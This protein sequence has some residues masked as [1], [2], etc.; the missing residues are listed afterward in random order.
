M[1][2]TLPLIDDPCLPEPPGQAKGFGRLLIDSPEDGEELEALP[3]RGLS[4]SSRIEGLNARTLVVTRFRNFHETPLRAVYTFPLPSEA[5]VTSFRLKADGRIIQ[6]KVLERGEALE[7]H[8]EAIAKGHTSALLEEEAGETFTLEL[9]NIPPTCEVETELELVEELPVEDRK[10]VWRFPLVCGEKYIPGRPLPG[11]PSGTGHAPDTDLVPEGSRISPPR[12]LPGMPNPIEASFRLTLADGTLPEGVEPQASLELEECEVC[13]TSPEGRS[14]VL[15]DRVTAPERDLILRWELPRDALQGDLRVVEQ[16]EDKGHF[17]ASI[18]V[19]ESD[20]APPPRD[21]VLLVDRSGSMGGWQ[22][23]AA[24]DCAADLLDMLRPGD[25]LA[26]LAFDHRA[27]GAFDREDPLAFAEIDKSTLKRA[28]RFLKTLNSRGGTEL[29]SLLASTWEKLDQLR[30]QQGGSA[31]EQAIFLLTDAQV[32]DERRILARVRG[33]KHP[34]PCYVIG[35]DQS[36]NRGL[37][38][39][40]V[41]ETGGELA[42]INAPTDREHALSAIAGAFARGVL[43]EARLVGEGLESGDVSLPPLVP[44]RPFRVAGRWLP[45]SVTQPL[46]L[47]ARRLDGEEIELVLQS[48]TGDPRL[49]LPLH[50][51]RTLADW[52]IAYDALPYNDEEGRQGLEKRIVDLSC[53]RQVLCRFTAFLAVDEENSI[54]IGK[55]YEVTQAVHET[56]SMSATRQH[57]KR[58]LRMDSPVRFESRF[59]LNPALDQIQP[60]MVPAMDEIPLRRQGKSKLYYNPMSHLSELSDMDAERMWALRDEVVPCLLFFVD[61]LGKRSLA[62]NA[63]VRQ[64]LDDPEGLTRESLFRLWQ[65]IELRLLAS[66]ATARQPR[67]KRGQPSWK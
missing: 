16:G 33:L 42:Q 12:L 23:Q 20:E 35:V 27:E 2:R 13:D 38:A 48:A 65:A 15:A 58:L 66:K 31:R 6:G 41:R 57:V 36:L 9:G 46:M 45:A 29:G 34:A 21:V 52:Q 56:M 8:D 19:P 67:R 55:E 59:C 64:L 22:I 30:R 32:G 18:V 54:R 7:K 17:L 50:A 61:L 24:R 44:G 26:L 51:K 39:R 37:L 53:K 4:V 63:D 43:R 1:T 5:A 62:G 60:D 11:D 47:R 28:R 40:L 49:V 14:F 3:V 25:R 10:A